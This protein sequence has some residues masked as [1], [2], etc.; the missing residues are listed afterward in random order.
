MGHV[1]VSGTAASAAYFLVYPLETIKT[2]TQVQSEA[3]GG[4]G[5]ARQVW[6]HMLKNES[7]AA[8]YRGVTAAIM[9]P[10]IC[11]SLRL[12]LYYC[13][14]DYKKQQTNKAL[15]SLFEKSYL[16]L[17]AGACSEIFVI[18]FDV[19]YVRMQAD[20]GLPPEK[21]INYKGTLNAFA[22]I[23][24]EEGLRTFWKGT[25]PSILKCMTVNFGM[26]TPYNECKERLSTRLGYTRLNYL[27]SAAIAGIG[28]S[29]LTLPVDNVKVKMQ[30]ARRSAQQLTIR[31]CLRNTYSKEGL[32]GFW[33][34]WA[35]F[36]LFFAPNV[37]LV[38]LF[39]D[40]FR[41]KVGLCHC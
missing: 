27:L 19:V 40:F 17:A 12:G 38:L 2:R 22:R 34:G 4:K 37:I 26:L 32:K 10:I 20:G 7:Y 41:I 15:L 28:A 5:S 13:F 23:A 1:A 8:F 3:L 9:H 35:P 25:I 24:K 14:E 36:Y 21:R 31:D 6:R 18:P 16:S 39:N 30:K 11:A 33:A 29:L